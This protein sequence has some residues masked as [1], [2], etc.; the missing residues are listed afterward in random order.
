MFDIGFLELLLV[1]IVGLLVLGP[2]K[3]PGAI[4]TVSLY[5]GKIRRSFNSVRAEIERELQADEIRQELHNQSV[6]QQLRETER[7]LRQGLGIDDVEVG[8]DGYP[9]TDEVDKTG[10][11]ESDDADAGQ[12]ESAPEPLA[13]A[14]DAAPT[15]PPDETASDEPSIDPTTRSPGS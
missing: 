6:L 5:V 2:D 9:L 7:E 15:P 10:K 4:R 12:R 1:S 3:L 13:R 14:S 8:K 11:V